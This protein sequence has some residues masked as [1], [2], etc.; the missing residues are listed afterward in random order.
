[1]KIILSFIS[2]VLTWFILSMLVIVIGAVIYTF[3]MLGVISILIGICTTI[4]QRL[5][6]LIQKLNKNEEK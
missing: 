5:I 4:L 6:N 3:P 1:M 2:D